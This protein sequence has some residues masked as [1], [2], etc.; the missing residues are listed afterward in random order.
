MS[1]SSCSPTSSG[2]QDAGPRPRRT[3]RSRSRSSTTHCRAAPWSRTTTMFSSRG[4]GADGR[5]RRLAAEG[6]RLT[7]LRND[8]LNP[9]R[10][11]WALG[12]IELAAGDPAAALQSLEEKLRQAL[13][14]FGIGEPGWQPIL[15]DVIEALVSAGQPRRC[16]DS[17]PAARAAGGSARSPFG[18]LRQLYGVAP[19]CCSPTSGRKKRQQPPN[20]LLRRSRSSGFRSTKCSRADRRGCSQTPR[21]PSP[22]GRRFVKCCDRD[23]RGARRYALARAGA[24]RAEASEPAPTPR[25]E[26]DERGGAG[27]GAR[28]PGPREPRGRGAALHDHL[29]R[30]GPPRGSHHGFGVAGAGASFMRGRRGRSRAR[31]SPPFAG[32]AEHILEL[33]VAT[34]PSLELVG[35][36]GEQARLVSFAARLSEGSRRAPHPEQARDRQDDPLARGNGRCGAPRERACSSR[37]VQRR[38][39]RSPLERS[40]ICSTPRSKRSPRRCPNHSSA[41]SPQR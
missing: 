3:P 24:R 39:C 13:D 10:I 14:T 7:E 37:A 9:S 26:A 19:C 30:R 28:R 8:H 2:A 36:A 11:R 38:R 16:G 40:W 1:C 27:G 29:D 4:H 31:G 25:S 22:A 6:L 20:R 34:T 18:L 15:P 35:R 23:P 17:A 33:G 21:R 5:A 12:H 41:R 32:A